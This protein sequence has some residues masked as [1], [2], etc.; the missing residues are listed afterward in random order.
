MKKKIA[1]VTLCLAQYRK[2]FY[3]RIFSNE[4]YEITVYCQDSINGLNLRLIHDEYDQ[5]RV[6]LVKFYNFGDFIFLWQ[7]VPWRELYFNYDYIFIDGNPRVL[8][9]FLMATLYSLLGKKIILW[10]MV[11]SFKDNPVN[12]WLRVTWMRM[13]KFHFLYNEDEIEYLNGI[14]FKKKVMVA[15]NNG[16]D[17]KLI[18]DEIL[19]WSEE[20]LIKWRVG[21]FGLATKFDVITLGRLLPNKYEDLLYALKELKKINANIKCCIIGDGI[22]RENLSKLSIE[23]GLQENIYFAGALYLESELCPYMLSSKICVHPT[24]MGLTIMHVFG[25]SLPIITHDNYSKHGPEMVAM[26]DKTNG[27]LYQYN[28][29]KDMVAKITELLN[30]KQLL[31][32]LSKNANLLVKEKYNTEMM[33]KNFFELILKVK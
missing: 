15:M 19:L 6:K 9:H 29:L 12:K 30:D 24:A 1:I 18:D 32:K 20:K 27:L 26:R 4:D 16:L 10:S 17:Q 13:F 5:E 31:N 23:L 21:K 28:D 33:S 25:Y 22:A 3:D 11:H 14:G 8:N 2:G 7:K